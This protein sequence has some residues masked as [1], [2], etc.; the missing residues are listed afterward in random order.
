MPKEQVSD[1][2]EKRRQKRRMGL[3]KRLA[4]N[5]VKM[6]MIK[7]GKKIKKD[8]LGSLKEVVL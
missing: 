1:N 2:V 6:D 3:E 8:N 4:E 7:R 5:D